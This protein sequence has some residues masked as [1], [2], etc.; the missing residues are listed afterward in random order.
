MADDIG[1]ILK[2][3]NDHLTQRANNEFKDSGITMSQMRVLM[4][5]GRAGDSTVTLRDIEK[6]LG[7]SHP[8]VVGLVK[9]LE[10]KGLITSEVSVHDKRFRIVAPTETGAVMLDM[11][12]QARADHERKLLEGLDGREVEALRA[13]LTRILKNVE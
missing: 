6:H 5:L 3:I 12:E 4:F 7:V 9:R 13:M 8:T 11:A 10:D 1:L 2:Q